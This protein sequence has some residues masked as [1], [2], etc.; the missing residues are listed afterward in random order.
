[1]G[2][3]SSDDRLDGGEHGIHVEGPEQDCGRL[4]RVVPN[5]ATFSLS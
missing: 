5:S 3:S 1:M 2:L 4:G